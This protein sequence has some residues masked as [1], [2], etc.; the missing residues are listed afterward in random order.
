MQGDDTSLAARDLLALMLPLAEARTSPPPMQ[1]AALKLLSDWTGDASP[2][3]PQPLIFTAW[4]RQ[5]NRK[6]YG[7][8][9]G[10]DFAR[11]SWSLRPTF[12][13]HVLTEAPQWCD[14]KTT[15]AV[16]T[17]EAQIQSAFASA[18]D[19]LAA[20]YGPV[21]QHWRWGDAHRV[22]FSHRILGRLPVLGPWLDVVLPTPGDDFTIDRGTTSIRNDAAPFAHVHG[23]SLRAIYDLD[24]LA[25]SRFIIAGGQSGNPLSP[26]YANMV[27][28]WRDVLYVAMDAPEGD[29]HRLLLVPKEGEP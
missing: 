22:T 21:P 28:R 29:S 12:I 11:L 13:A 17:C 23:P 14:D 16:E 1:A 25:N 18:L 24:D 4:L 5:L 19:E 10:P 2:D 9:L 7:D 15:D 27:E 6:I 26:L 3:L 20:H 8:E